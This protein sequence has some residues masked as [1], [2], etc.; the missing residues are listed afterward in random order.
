LKAL[1]QKNLRKSKEK[2]EKSIQNDSKT[3]IAIDSNIL[4]ISLSNRSSRKEESIKMDS[5]TRIP[6]EDTASLSALNNKRQNYEGDDGG[7]GGGLQSTV[8]ISFTNITKNTSNAD[9]IFQFDDNDKGEGEEGSTS[10]DDDDGE[11]ENN[12]K[13]EKL[14]NNN[15]LLVRDSCEFDDYDPFVRT[16][17]TRSSISSMYSFFIDNECKQNINMF[18]PQQQQ[19]QEQ[20]Q[21]SIADKSIQKIYK[22]SFSMLSENSNKSTDIIKKNESSLEDILDEIEPST[23]PQQQ[24][25]SRHTSNNNPNEINNDSS[26]NKE[27]QKS[28]FKNSAIKVANAIGVRNFLKGIN[29]NNNDLQPVENRTDLKSHIKGKKKRLKSKSESSFTDS[30]SSSFS[31]NDDDDN[32]DSKS[33]NQSVSSRSNQLDVS[34][35]SIGGDEKDSEFLIRSPSPNHL[36]KYLFLYEDHYFKHCN[37]FIKKKPCEDLTI[38]CDNQNENLNELNR[39]L[40]TVSDAENKPNQRIEEPSVK[41]EMDK[42]FIVTNENNTSKSEHQPTTL[43]FKNSLRNIFTSFKQSLT[44]KK[45]NLVIKMNSFHLTKKFFEF[46]R[47][48]KAAK[49]LGIVMGIFIICWLPFFIYNVITG[50]FRAD[51]PKYHETIFFVFTWLGYINSGCNPV[52]YA[53]SSRDFRRAFYKILCP[54]AFHRDHIKRRKKKHQEYTLI[55]MA[56]YNYK[57]NQ[58]SNNNA[59]CGGGGGGGGGGVSINGQQS[60]INNNNNNNKFDENVVNALYSTTVKTKNHHHHH[61]RCRH[62]NQHRGGGSGRGDHKRHPCR[63][64]KAEISNKNCRFCQIYKNYLISNAQ[65]NNQDDNNNSNNEA[66]L[67]NMIDTFTAPVITTLTSSNIADCSPIGEHNIVSYIFFLTEINF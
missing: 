62:H 48:Q 25:Q 42:I 44:N 21:Q 63:Q 40:L 17:M 49:T 64:C 20:Q 58:N 50:I 26:D 14:T 53:F 15:T 60:I 59:T 35:R 6:I 7:R 38:F 9:N 1:K 29:R 39:N 8:S 54:S 3:S 37:L 23:S 31:S 30:C 33:K 16:I 5:F 10:C 28:K 34:S 47:E 46:S 19:Q 36:K 57:L 55:Q 43:S 67:K 18:K 41:Y 51:L 24:Q 11:I 61:H 45:N 66:I 65:N 13:I 56:A 12:S 4:P 2:N 27:A 52:I 22:K 32:G